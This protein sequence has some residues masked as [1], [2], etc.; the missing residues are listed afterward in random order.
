MAPYKTC[1]SPEA[2]RTPNSAVSCSTSTRTSKRFSKRDWS[3]K[4]IS[5]ETPDRFT[6]LISRVASDRRLRPTH[7]SLYVALCDAWIMSSFQ[8]CYNVSRKQL[9]T[10]S[11]IQSK[12]TYHKTMSE[13]ISMGYI[14]YSPSYH[15]MEGSKV[16]LLGLMD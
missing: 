4:S 5:M 11:R 13:L 12:T 1:E 7:I 15:P 14:H 8:L 6:N 3:L 10:L 9:M 16:T 2:C